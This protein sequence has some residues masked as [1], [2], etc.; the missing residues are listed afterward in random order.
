[1]K[2]PIRFAKRAL[3]RLRLAQGGLALTEFALTAPLLT[4]LGMGG[5]ELSNYALI[6]LRINQAASHIADN[7]S[8]I[9]ESSN[10]SALRIYEA[11]IQDLFIGVRLHSGLGSDFYEHGRVVLSSL[12]QNADGGQWIHWQRCMGKKNAASAYGEQGKGSTGTGFS[13]MGPSGN[14]IQAG[15]GEAVMFVEIAYDYQPLVS[16]DMVKPF[17]SNRTITA[18]SAFIVRGNRDLA[19]LYTLST[20]APTWSCEKFDEV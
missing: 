1:M 20:P 19:K 10:L 2:G 12:E 6:N 9:G 7:A 14:E 4:L 17:T 15:S 18:Q 13:G 3:R 11:D 16:I 8:R 5:L